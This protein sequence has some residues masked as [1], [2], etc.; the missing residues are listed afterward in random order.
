MLLIKFR[1]IP[2]I[3]F[4]DQSNKTTKSVTSPTLHAIN[5]HRIVTVIAKRTMQRF[6]L[7]LRYSA[8][9]T[10]PADQQI[11]ITFGESLIF[12]RFFTNRTS[13]D[14][15]SLIFPLFFQNHF[16]SGQPISGRDIF[17]E[18]RASTFELLLPFSP[19]H[20]SQFPA[21]QFLHRL[22]G[23]FLFLY[24]PAPYSTEKRHALSLGSRVPA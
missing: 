14:H 22:P 6:F 20:L 2:A 11:L 24:I 12:K 3:I 10:I 8:G 1:E 19:I 9:F 21:E 5:I 18:L 4:I 23:F 13:V 16:D 7:V 17:F 15:A